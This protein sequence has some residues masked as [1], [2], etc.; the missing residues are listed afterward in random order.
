MRTLTIT[1]L[2]SMM[3]LAGTGAASAQNDEQPKFTL[4]PTG[5]VLFD[6]AVYSPDGDGFADGVA[7][8]DIRMGL[9]AA[10]G[11]WSAKIDVGYGFKKLGFKDVFIQYEFNKSN[12]LRLGYFVHQ[13]GLNASTSSSMK[14]AM[15]APISDN[16]FAATSRNMGLMYVL[17]RPSVFLGV[18]AFVSGDCMGTHANDMAKV[19]AGALN[20]L[21][22]RPWHDTGL[23][24]QLG[25]SLWYQS[26]MHTKMTADDGHT[27]ASPGYFDYST[28]FPTRVCSTPLLGAKI[29]DA[30]GVFKLS[31][32]AVFA[33]GRIGVEG[34][35]Y[36]MRVTRDAS[37]PAYVAQGGYALLRGILIGKDYGYSA[38]DAGL[39]TPAPK[40]LE[41]VLGYNYTDANST[42]AGIYGGRTNDYSVTLNYYINKYM[43][44]RLRYSYT[45][46]SDSDVQRNRHV[47][48][49]QARL[50]FKF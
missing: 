20:R 17:N 6:G 19:S 3:M 50:Q 41:M 37:R 12:L 16:F 47:N 40:T 30:K 39:A 23:V 32:E 31:P 49:V 4:T 43:V 1:A 9:K 44:A 2:A 24:G 13:F 28:T 46:V 29:E 35:Y 34:Q 10:Y 7:M 36:Y 11:N 42:K 25:L 21:V 27:Y 38:A 33:K 48:I 26:A 8:P 14:P 18:S 5:R 15:E 45:D 22:Y